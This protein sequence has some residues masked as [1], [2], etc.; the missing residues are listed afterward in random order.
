MRPRKLLRMLTILTAFCLLLGMATSASAYVTDIAVYVNE[1][2]SPIVIGGASNISTDDKGAW[3]Y[4]S[5]SGDVT[6]SGNPAAFNADPGIGWSVNATNA[7]NVAANVTVIFGVFATPG[8]PGPI[9]VRSTSGVSLTDGTGGGTGSDGVASVIPY[10]DPGLPANG[11]NIAVNYTG[12]ID[13]ADPNNLIVV[14]SWGTNPGFTPVFPDNLGETL[15][16]SYLF[17][18]IKP[19]GSGP[20]DVFFEVVSFTLSAHDQVGLSGNCSFLVPIPP[21]ALLLGSGMLG[22][23]LLGWRRKRQS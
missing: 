5:N 11:G 13:P 1:G 20:N 19:V 15:V 12:Y 2:S 16:N 3:A 6:V 4:Q 22:M 21:T 17:T 8:Y 9:K 18:G 7:S 23:A 14:N 10:Q